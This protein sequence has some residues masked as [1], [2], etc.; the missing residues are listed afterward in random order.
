MF[1]RDVSKSRSDYALL[2]ELPVAIMT[3]SLPDFTIVYANKA[4]ME[5]LEKIKAV[6]PVPPGEIVGQSIDIFHKNPEHQRKMLRNPDNLPHRARIEADGEILDLQVTAMRDASG[7]YVGPMLTWEIVT[8]KVRNE[9]A[10]SRQMQMLNNLPIN[11]ML[12]DKDTFEIVYLNDTSRRTLRQIEHLLPIKVEEMEGASI[13]VFHKKPEHQRRILSD[14]SN[15]PWQSIISLGDQKLNLEISAL[16]AP[17]G[18]YMAAMLTWSVV[19]ENVKMADTVKSVVSQVSS[20][21]AQLQSNSAAMAES[22]G[23]ANSTATTV[24]SATEELSSSIVEISRRMAEATEIVNNSVRES[25]RSTGMINSLSE[26]AQRIGEVVS[27]I[28]NIAAQTNLLALNATIEAA[29]AGDAGK[30]FAVVANEVK[31]LATQTAKATEEIADQIS[32]IQTA[33]S[34]AVEANG[35]VTR[36]IEQ[37]DEIATGVAAGVEEQS[38]ATQ[39]VATNI[40]EVQS[41]SSRVGELAQEVL[42]ASKQLASEGASLK[43]SCD[44]FMEKTI[45]A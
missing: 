23:V 25:R 45:K 37:L 19:T 39:E 31:S 43:T 2:D 22:A 33:V 28:Q 1:V 38:A 7:T 15:L 36:T 16:N 17:D 44:A 30:G 29:R 42:L 18:S 34:D 9:T 21:S 5:A 20:A 11:V 35:A 41:A 14:P 3:C 4:S 10:I 6:L 32:Q 24:A 12:A 40:V 8:E 26:A 13:D 27:L